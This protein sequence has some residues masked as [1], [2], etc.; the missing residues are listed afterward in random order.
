[1]NQVGFPSFLSDGK[2]KRVSDV[3]SNKLDN[4]RLLSLES[5][6]ETGDK[7]SHISYGICFVPVNDKLRAF[8]GD[9]F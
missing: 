6:K 8:L 7:I 3:L 2:L 1:V 5:G 9:F 4:N